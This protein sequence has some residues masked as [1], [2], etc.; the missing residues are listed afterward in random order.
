L[1]S[2]PFDA[3]GLSTRKSVVIEKGILKSYLLDRYS[4]RKLGLPST[5]NAARGVGDAPTVSPTNFFISPGTSAPEEIVRSIRTGL[6]VTEL[7]GFG[8][9]L[10]T[11]DYSRG[12]AGIWIEGGELAYPVEEITIAGKLREMLKGIEMV[13]NDLAFTR[14]VAAPT[15]K[16][17][18]M[19]IAGG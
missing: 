12:A 3:E 8:V 2:K 9:N 11:G 13:G 5:A 1:G 6:Y 7:I 15:L 10:I 17:S 19:M 16:F 14:R 18:E 4:G